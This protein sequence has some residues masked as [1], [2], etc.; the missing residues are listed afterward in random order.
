MKKIFISVC[1]LFLFATGGFCALSSSCIGFYGDFGIG[2]GSYGEGLGLT[3]RIH[4]IPIMWG[5]SWDFS[6]PGYLA[7]SGDYWVIN[8]PLAGALDY[9]IGIGAFIG[10]STYFDFGVRLPIGFQFFPLPKLE[11]FLE[12]APTLAFIPTL[13]LGGEFRLGVRF[14]L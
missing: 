10:V 3:F 9:Y 1:L 11:V 8:G 5:V 7:I 14:Y 12:G 13:S 6:S 2:N 4:P